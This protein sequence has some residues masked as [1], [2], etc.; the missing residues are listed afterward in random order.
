MNYELIPEYILNIVYK[1]LP[2]IIHQKNI[3]F[4]NR[5]EEEFYNKSDIELN[6]RTK[7]IDLKYYG[8]NPYLIKSIKDIRESIF[9]QKYEINKTEF[10]ISK[11]Y[12]FI[13]GFKFENLPESCTEIQLQSNNNTLNIYK[14]PKNNTWINIF[15]SP[16]K[17]FLQ[18]TGFSILTLNFNFDKP[19][20]KYPNIYIKYSI[21]DI[22]YFKESLNIKYYQVK[23]N[24]G[25]YLL[26]ID[27]GYYG[28]HL[29]QKIEN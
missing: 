9:I 10:I 5:K 14:N 11:I 23:S 15:E 1:N 12:D 7:I 21:V 16:E 29:L 27:N 26:S 17:L 18:N 20:E 13:Y 8:D 4:A 3:E 19:V 22:E 28:I 25:K 2:F 6:K 24:I